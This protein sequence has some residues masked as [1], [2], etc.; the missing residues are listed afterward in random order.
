MKRG[1]ARREMARQE[2]ARISAQAD[3]SAEARQAMADS[4]GGLAEA[5]G[6]TSSTPVEV[7]T[8]WSPAA[9]TTTPDGLVIPAAGIGQGVRDD[10]PPPRP[11]PAEQ[12][13]AS[14]AH[15][16]ETIRL[17]HI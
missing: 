6:W 10:P 13:Q 5:F 12:L 17:R 9:P 1:D 11:T 7:T 14:I 3:R 4:L 8:G 15:S 2:S 16:I